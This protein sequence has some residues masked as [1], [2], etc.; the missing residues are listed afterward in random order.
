MKKNCRFICRTCGNE[1]DSYLNKEDVP[2]WGVLYT[3]CGACRKVMTDYFERQMRKPK[4][5]VEGEQHLD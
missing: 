5:R 1:W 3:W 4:I 2:H